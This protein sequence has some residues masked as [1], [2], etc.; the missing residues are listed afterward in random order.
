M[1]GVHVLRN[2]GTA[3]EACEASITRLENSG[4][5]NSGFGSNLTWDG[6]VECE[7]S[8]MDGATL[9]FGACTNVRTVKNPIQLARNICSRQGRMLTFERI[10]PMIL[11]GDGAE[12]YAKELG[13]QLVDPSMLVS[14]K[15]QR[16]YEHYKSKIK[17]ASSVYNTQITSLDTVGAVC[18]DG[19]GNIAA[20]CSSGGLILKISGRVGQAASFGAGC[21][22]EVI[23]DRM[24]GTCTT[25]NGE[26]LIKTLL[27][28]EL[29]TDLL[30][31]TCPTTSLHQTFKGKFLESKLLPRDKELYGGSLAIIFN[32]GSEDGELLWGHTTK[33]LCLGYMSTHQKTPK[34]LSIVLFEI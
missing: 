5:T 27:A 18:V 6:K 21:W 2:G 15:A 16:C 10:P 9:Q 28:R 31:C 25:G 33:S 34:V 17:T 14:S 11:A 8:I 1:R 13:L 24:V 19:N 3:L 7:A 26:Y 32:R 30:S 23:D 29:A 20:G 4:N 22:A 12:L